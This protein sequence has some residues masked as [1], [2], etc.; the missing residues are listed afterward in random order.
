MTSPELSTALPANEN[1]TARHAVTE[2]AVL[3]NVE[4]T[5][6]D[7]LVQE[8]EGLHQVNTQ[9]V[10]TQNSKVLNNIPNFTTSSTPVSSETGHSVKRITPEV[11]NFFAIF[12]CMRFEVGAV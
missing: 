12:K 7:E 1:S 10:S 8:L 3:S 2:S 5:E 11:S 9:Q 4:K 6:G